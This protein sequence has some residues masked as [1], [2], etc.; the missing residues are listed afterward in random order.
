MLTLLLNII[1][2][3]NLMNTLKGIGL[4]NFFRNFLWEN[5]KKKMTNFSYKID[6]SLR[7]Y[8]DTAYFAEIENLLLKVL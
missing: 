1:L 4:R 3:K 5:L 6:C 8:L 2:M 7:I